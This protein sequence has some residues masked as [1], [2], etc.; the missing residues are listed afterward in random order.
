MKKVAL[1]DY[2]MGNL[3]SVANALRFL[4]ADVSVVDDPRDL[5]RAA[6]IILPGVG[7]FGDGMANLHKR[8]FVTALEQCVLANETPFLGICLGMQLLATTGLEHGR[9]QGLGWIPGIVERLPGK[10]GDNVVRVPHIGWNDAHFVPGA[11]LLQGLG[12]SACYY[13]VHSYHLVAVDPS[14]VTATCEYGVSFAAI[15]EK[16]NIYG[17]QFHPEKSHR[18]GLALLRNFLQI[19]AT[20][21]AEEAID[22]CLAAQERTACAQ[23]AVQDSSS[24]RQSCQ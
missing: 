21:R 3:R 8:G 10:V 6:A 20:E 5:A 2:G 22:P 23:R 15:I 18:A 17:T 7:A 11:R 12:Q 24:Y 4:G 19:G 16:R 1:I 13:F 9:H 14:I